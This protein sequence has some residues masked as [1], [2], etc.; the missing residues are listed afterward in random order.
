MS[1]RYNDINTCGVPTVCGY[2]KSDLAID[3]GDLA[4]AGN[5]YVVYAGGKGAGEFH[6]VDTVPT[7]Q[8]EATSPTALASTA[9]EWRTG[10]RYAPMATSSSRQPASWAFRSTSSRICPSEADSRWHLHARG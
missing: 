1:S 2:L 10:W 7:M 6:V 5:K 3:Q 8:N 4:I 9:W